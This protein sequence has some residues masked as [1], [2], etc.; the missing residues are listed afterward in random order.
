MKWICIIALTCGWCCTVD[1]NAFR[2]I[3]LRR[4]YGAKRSTLRSEWVIQLRLL[5][6][7]LSRPT[8]NRADRDSGR[9]AL[10]IAARLQAGQAASVAWSIVPKNGQITQS[11]RDIQAFSTAVGA[12]PE[13]VLQHV[14][15]GLTE[16]AR[17]AAERDVVLAGPR[18][19]A[20][21]FAALPLVIIVVT[22]AAGVPLVSTYTDLGIGSIAMILGVLLYTLGVIWMRALHERAA[23]FGTVGDGKTVL[24]LAVIADLIAAGIGAGADIASVVGAIGRACHVSVLRKIET[25]LLTGETWDSAWSQSPPELAGL[26]DVL[27]PAWIDGIAPGALLTHYATGVRA[28]RVRDA[29]AAARRM[30]VAVTLPLGLCLLPAFVLLVV[31]PL[32]LHGVFGIEMG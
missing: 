12:A 3:V 11:L 26:V 31:V 13:F 32:I 25:A 19:I 15:Q 29:Q 24:D 2:L 7:F 28:D 22:S 1:A 21:L 10:E 16:A 20:R 17:A 23:R 27:K 5:W 30:G 6:Q 14:A 4:T 18:A 8:R 9:L